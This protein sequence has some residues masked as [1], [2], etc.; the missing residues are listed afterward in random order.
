MFLLTTSPWGH[1]QGESLRRQVTQPF[2]PFAF[3]EGQEKEGGGRNRGREGNRERGEGG[4]Y[5]L[6]SKIYLK[7]GSGLMA[8]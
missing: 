5:M 3:N 7:S 8:Q 4:K 2:S 6:K 1:Q